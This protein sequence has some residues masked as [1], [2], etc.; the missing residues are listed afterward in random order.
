ML[1]NA[2]RTCVRCART[3]EKEI[4]EKCVVCASYYCTECAHRGFGR[5]FCSESCAKTYFYGDEEDD[6][7]TAERYDVDE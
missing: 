6:Y 7:S 1:Q 3:D 4:L 5:R 2:E